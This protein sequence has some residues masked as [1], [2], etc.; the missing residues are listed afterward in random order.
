MSQK[1]PQGSVMSGAHGWLVTSTLLLACAL[2]LAGCADGDPALTQENIDTA[3]AALSSDPSGWVYFTTNNP[4][5]PQF[6]ND[7]VVLIPDNQYQAA[8][9]ALSKEYYSPPYSV[10]FEYLMFDDDGGVLWNWNSAD[11]VVL[12]LNKDDR[13]Y[14]GGAALPTGYARAFIKDGTGYGVHFATYGTRSIFLQDGNGAMLAQTQ[15]YA[16]YTNGKWA[17]VHVDVT[18]SRIKVFFNGVPQLDWSGDFIETGWSVAIGAATGAADSE[19]RIR[20][21]RVIQRH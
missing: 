16:V 11:G 19:H 8:A 12:M 5:Y 20:G 2:P 14:T 3:S 21:A 7:E 9:V 6:I 17:K 18:S 1:E 10:E 15:N 13:P 4:G